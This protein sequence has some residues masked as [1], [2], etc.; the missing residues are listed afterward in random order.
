MWFFY[1]IRCSDQSLYAG[2][3]TDVERRVRDHNTSSKGAKYTRSRRPVFL[4]LTR[5]FDNKSAALKYEWGFKKLSKRNKEDACQKLVG[6]ENESIT[7]NKKKN[8]NME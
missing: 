7:K 3:T 5:S 4:V 6:G 2:I 8:S 1:V